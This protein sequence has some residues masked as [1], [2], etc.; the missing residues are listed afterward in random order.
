MLQYRV[1]F[2]DH[3]HY[4][5]AGTVISCDTDDEARVAAEDLLRTSAH[6]AIEVWEDRRQVHEAKKAAVT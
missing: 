3:R 5:V 2:L 4:V 1:Y 6:R